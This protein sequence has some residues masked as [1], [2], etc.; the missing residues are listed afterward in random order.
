MTTTSSLPLAKHRSTVGRAVENS[1]TR[2]LGLAGTTDFTVTRHV[3]VPTRDGVELAA[4]LYRP[5]SEAVGTLL[6]RGPYG[7]SLPIA[8]AM[9][10]VFA[11]RGYNCL[12]VSS[13][14]TFGSGGTFAPMET[15]ADD[16]HDVVA[17][18]LA[19]PWFT[20]TF[21]T[22][23]GS[24]LGHTQWAILADPPAE[25]VAAVISVGP[26]DFHEHAWGTGAFKLDFLGWSNQIVHQEDT[27]PVVG[28]LRMA[29]TTN[30]RRVSAALDELPL[31]A[32]AKRI[33]EGR[34]PWYTD[35][36]S[37]P[38][39][40]DPFWAPMQHGV[41]LDRIEI[42]VLLIG[43]WQDIFLGQTIE[44]YRRL[45]DRG[46]DVA[47]TIGPW[48]HIQ[49]GTKGLSLTTQET[50]D[51]LDEH[52][53]KRGG[54]R[55]PAPVHVFVTGADEWRD[56]PSWPPETDQRSFHLHPGG[57]L[58]E[59]APPPDAA[60]SAFTFDPA[61][62]T[63]TVGGAALT[64]KSVVDDTAL[65]ERA[66]V[67]TFT[68]PVLLAPV[69]VLGA[70]VVELAHQSDNPHADLFVRV[71]EV[72]RHG[73]SHNVTE[74]YVRL[75]PARTDEPVSVTLRDTAYRFAAGSRIRLLIAGGSHPKYARNL[76]TGENP[77]T[78]TGLRPARHSIAHG[79]GASRLLLP[80]ARV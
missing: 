52:L 41:A 20:G 59:E 68:G 6:V 31:V 39:A 1:I 75:D 35:W 42:P 65:A 15:E 19:Q 70:P 61:H 58:T 10:R 51:W 30:A 2:L 36:V 4:D 34:A 25:L 46:Q 28:A 9:A 64:G 72:D 7:R 16:G 80:T 24:Y 11:A 74:G 50:F 13:R 55:R 29:L 32:P 23:G 78:G 40:E 21:A 18:M 44:Q 12:F 67:L 26:H 69:E 5:T 57:G 22:V 76:G 62:P 8:F 49:V 47:L 71:S 73:R 43:G 37:R 27:G 56:L 63:P 77:G 79:G 3:R 54:R 60:P 45:L 48:S 17:W 38:A 33:L 53:A 14:G 66:D